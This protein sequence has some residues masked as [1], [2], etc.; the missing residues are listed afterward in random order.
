MM[1]KLIIFDLDGT[2]INSIKD[3]ATSTN[4]AL[5][6]L[7]FPTHPTDDY[8][9]MVGNGIN[10]LFERALP[11]GKKNE[12]NISN[13]RELFL[14]HYDK[15]NTVYTHPYKEIPEVLK[16]LQDK[17]YLLAVASNKYQQ[18]TEKLV[19][20]FFPNITFNQVFGQRNN[21]PSKPDP[22]VLL[23]ILENT[24]T[25]PEEA[26]MI[27]DSNVD[28]QTANRANI[29]GCGVSWGFRSIEELKSQNPTYI[30]NEAT[31]ILSILNIEI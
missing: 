9:M 19:N 31:D 10:K 25:S 16:T 29:E 26:L 17:G 3:L 21:I 30:I 8:N 5:E 6:Q 20:H 4:Y 22:T 28:M 24:N 23:E 12:K 15:H 1:K 27:G 13:M 7:K 18:G 14:A 11:E 2:L